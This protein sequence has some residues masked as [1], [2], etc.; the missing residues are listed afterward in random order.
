MP[1]KT[2]QSEDSVL[3]DS[4]SKRTDVF[5]NVEVPLS[6]S[7]LEKNASSPFLNKS[8][9]KPPRVFHRVIRTNCATR[10]LTPF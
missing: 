1:T 6:T 9:T 2:N 3:S 8:D 5:S 7:P 10:F 4:P